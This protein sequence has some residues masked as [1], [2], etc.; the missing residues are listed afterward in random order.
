VS[1]HAAREEP[2]FV[3]FLVFVGY[4][5]ASWWSKSCIVVIHEPM[6]VHGG[7]ELR[8]QTRGPQEIYSDLRLWQEPVPEVQWEGG[9]N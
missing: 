3:A 6:V 4:D 2:K 9:V 8:M 7:R 5:F 1:I